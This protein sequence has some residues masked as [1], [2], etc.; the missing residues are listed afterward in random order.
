[1]HI[2]IVLESKIGADQF[3]ELGLLAESLGIHGIWIQ[4]YAQAPDAFMTA[5]PLAAASTTIRVGIAVISP[6]ESH[7][8]K[9]AN[10]VLT[11]NE[12]TRGRAAVVVAGGGQ[13]PDVIKVN[14]GKRMTGLREAL[15]IITQACSDNTLNYDGEVYSAQGFSARWATRQPPLILAG[16]NGPKMTSMA[17]GI[18]DGIM[19]SD[20]QPEMFDWSLPS[21]K[22]ALN[23][24]NR[25]EKGFRLNNFLSWH[26]KE[27]REAALFEAQR[28]LIARAWLGRQWIKH[29]LSPDDVEM[30]RANTLSFL[31]AYIDRTNLIEGIPPRII[32]NLVEGLTIS[33]DLDDMARHIER[34]KLFKAAGFTEIALGLQDDPEDS[35]RLIAEHVLP[36]LQ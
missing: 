1:M 7:P 25:A 18:A 24:T 15:E 13:W 2:D 6:Y 17:A 36:A 30:V 22:T 19:M 23:N 5:M 10:A 9:I 12:I 4:N 11:L 26:I 3:R 21:L 14:Y 34:L 29:Y 20:V 35:L 8:L 33:G 32:D 31:K 27:D 16:A 28:E